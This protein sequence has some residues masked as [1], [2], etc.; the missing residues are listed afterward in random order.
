MESYLTP[1]YKTTVRRSYRICLSS[2]TTNNTEQISITTIITFSEIRGRTNKTIIIQ[3]LRSHVL[4]HV[5]ECEITWNIISGSGQLY[6]G[7]QQIQN[8]FCIRF[9]DEKSGY[10]FEVLEKEYSYKFDMHIKELKDI[11]GNIINYRL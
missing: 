11:D 7:M 5:D 1:T 9:G 6:L 8:G 10:S 2:T 4:L 3:P